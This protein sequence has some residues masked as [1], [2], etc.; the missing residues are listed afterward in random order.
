M[1]KQRLSQRETK[2]PAGASPGPAPSLARA[3]GHAATRWRHAP[4]R[5]R[6]CRIPSRAPPRRC[7][8]GGCRAAAGARCGQADHG[9]GAGD[10]CYA[11]CARE[12]QGPRRRG[13]RG[14]RSGG[15]AREEPRERHPAARR[16]RQRR[17]AGPLCHFALRPAGPGQPAADRDGCAGRAPE[18]VGVTPQPRS[19]AVRP[20]N[21]WITRWAPPSRISAVNSARREANSL[22]VPVR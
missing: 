6:P 12:P 18:P 8:G 1:S 11:G 19:R 5:E 3:D 21:S 22:I 16:C 20:C 10:R 17:G 13:G 9:A 7:P 4:R 15:S 14:A 2:W